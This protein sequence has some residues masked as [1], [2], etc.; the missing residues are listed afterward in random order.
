MGPFDRFNDRAKRVVALAQDEAIRLKHD[1]IGPEHLLLGLIREGEGIAGRVLSSLGVDL[2]ITRRNVE[3]NA[4]RGIEPHT[5]IQMHPRTRRIV[6]LAVK[7]A[8]AGGSERVGTEHLLLALI[9][10][11]GEDAGSAAAKAVA[12]LGVAAEKIRQEVVTRAASGGS[13][14]SEPG[15][16]ARVVTGAGPRRMSPE[17][18]AKFKD[19]Q[20]TEIRRVIAVGQV[21][22]VGDASL[23]LLS[24]EIYA[25]GA[26]A[27]FLVAQR[28]PLGAAPNAFGIPDFAPKLTDDQGTEYAARP[29]GGSGGTGGPG[30]MVHWRMAQAFAPALPDAAQKLK[31]TADAVAWRGPGPDP[32]QLI[33]TSRVSG[34]WEWEIDV[35]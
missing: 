33:E 15:R 32:Q 29:W 2:G 11:A 4:P 26:V 10:V 16:W 28:R 34:S 17:A 8:D 5:E 23:T 9:R 14:P 19:Q 25:D 35:A 24:F 6:E 21:R 18:M 3:E 27:Q 31:L 7:E 20:L 22:T 30:G 12:S 1:Y 13:D